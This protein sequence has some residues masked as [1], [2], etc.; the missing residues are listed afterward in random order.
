MILRWMGSCKCCSI[1]RTTCRKTMCKSL[2][3]ACILRARKPGRRL[4][5]GS[6]LSLGGTCRCVAFH[7]HNGVPTISFQVAHAGLE[8]EEP[9]QDLALMPLCGELQNMSAKWESTHMVRRRQLGQHQNVAVHVH[10]NKAALGRPT[11]QNR[12]EQCT[13][14]DTQ[15]P[16]PCLLQCVAMALVGAHHYSATSRHRVAPPLPFS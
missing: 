4:S 2:I 5:S 1:V 15:Q 13:N 11:D 12:A 10:I 8:P 7:Y 14:S 16:R 6:R 9:R 3:L